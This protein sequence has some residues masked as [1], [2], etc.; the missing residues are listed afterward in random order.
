M[1][2]VKNFMGVY[3]VNKIVKPKYTPS[4]IIVNFSPEE[5][6]GTH[7]IAIIFINSELCIY[8]DPLDLPFVPMEIQQYMHQQSN[9]V[10]IL[11]YPIQNMFSGYCGFYCILAIL[12]H[13]NNFSLTDGL[14]SFPKLSLGNDEKCISTVVKLFKIY[15]LEH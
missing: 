10:Y 8:F 2:D 14:Q 5:L 6:P 12:L 4:Y 3:S 11:C 7:F 15:Y 13:A 9:L 1:K